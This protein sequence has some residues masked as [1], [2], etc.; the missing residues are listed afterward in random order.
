MKKSLKCLIF[1]MII[2]LVSNFNSMVFACEEDYLDNWMQDEDYCFYFDIYKGISPENVFMEVGETKDVKKILCFTSADYDYIYDES[3]QEWIEQGK[4]FDIVLNKLLVKSSDDSCISII[5]NENKMDGITE[6]QLKANKPG[7]CEIYADYYYNNKHYEIQTTFFVKGNKQDDN[8]ADNTI[9]NDNKQIENKIPEEVKKDTTNETPVKVENTTP[10]KSNENTV[11]T[12]KNTNSNNST[13]TKPNNEK[14]N[15]TEEQ[16]EKEDKNE[17]DADDKNKINDDKVEKNEI[18][19]VTT[20]ETQ[21][22]ENSKSNKDEKT[23]KV[24]III[25]V[26]SIILILTGVTIFARILI[27]RNNE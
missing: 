16:E 5:I 3:S 20:N 6:M 11:N 12:S 14:I 18:T 10:Q 1:I 24:N 22:I 2:L 27:K 19:T 15:K 9:I 25:I 17:I 4:Q 8:I 13:I 26:V 23:S 21:I 7:E